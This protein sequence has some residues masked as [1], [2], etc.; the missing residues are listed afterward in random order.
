VTVEIPLL[1]KSKMSFTDIHPAV[2]AVIAMPD[3]KCGEIH[4]ASLFTLIYQNT[5]ITFSTN[6]QTRQRSQLKSN[7]IIT[8]PKLP[9]SKNTVRKWK[10]EYD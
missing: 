6:F 2:F 1:L 9:Y 5:I 3:E 7:Q 10:I 8:I 4:K